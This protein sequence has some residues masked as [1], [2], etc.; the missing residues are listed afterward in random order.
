MTPAQTFSVKMGFIIF[1]EDGKITER[2]TYSPG[3]FSISL[4]QLKTPPPLHSSG[5]MS[6]ADG[7]L[8]AGQSGHQYLPV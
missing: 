6:G 8:S 3:C 4:E 2:A 1:M 5:V 7:I